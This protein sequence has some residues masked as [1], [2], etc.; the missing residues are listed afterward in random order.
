MSARMNDVHTNDARM[1]VEVP[2]DGAQSPISERPASWYAH[3]YTERF[4]MHLV[5][6][7]PRRKYPRSNNWGK[8]CLSEPG[9][10]VEFYTERP[11]WNMGVALGPSGMCSLDIDCEDSFR[12]ICECFGID[13]DALISQTPTVR[14]RGFRL[15]FRVP[16]GQTL[17]YHK[18][19]WPS[20]NDPTGTKHR[21]AVA[22]AQ[23]AKQ[24]GNT[25]RERRI[26]AVAK[27]WAA[28]TVFE[29]RAAGDGRQ[30]QDVLPPSIHPDTER[31]YAWHTQPRADWPEPPVWLMAMWTQFNAFKGQIR[32]MCPWAE[33]PKPPTRQKKATPLRYNE[34]GAR[35]GMSVIQ[36]FCA[37]HTLDE[38]LD[39][40]GYRQISERRYLSPHSSTG[41]PG[42]VMLPDANS[43]WIHHAS[44]PLCSESSGRP[45][46]AFDLYAAY[47]H[48]G[49][50]K[51]AVKQAAKDLGLDSRAPSVRPPAPVSSLS[52]A[53]NP[54][55]KAGAA[56]PAGA[57]DDAVAPTAAPVA[58]RP[59]VDF[60][61]PL[62]WANDQGKPLKHVDNLAE[63]CN[64]LGVTIRYNVI[65]KEEEI[66]IPYESFS[67]DNEANASLAWLTSECSLFGFPTDKLSEFVGYLADKNL[68]NPVANWIT[69][70]PWDGVCR[71]QDL[72][73]TVVAVGEHAREDIRRLKE[74]LIKRWMVSAVAAVMRP[75][76]VGAAGV[77]VFQGDQYIGKTKWFKTLVPDHLDVLKDGML[78]RPD[79]KDSV[80]QVCSY[81]LVE[82]GE[83]DATFRKSDI[84]ALKA[85]ITSDTDVLRRPYARRESRFAR[86]TVFFGSV[87]ER[88]FLHDPTGNRRYWTIECAHINHSHDI[89]MQQVWAEVL[90]MYERGESYYLSDA[91]MRMLNEHNDGFMAADPVEE[92][93]LGC[94]AWDDPQSLWQWR[95]VMDVMED[96]GIE[97]PS[98]GDLG[99]A[100]KVLRKLNGGQ[101]KRV[102]G[103][104]LL[105][106]PLKK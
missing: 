10:A 17:P 77:L 61:S 40:Y 27:R 12:L 74:V 54:A 91:E 84:A 106:A 28:F 46:N 1:D 26:R 24:A 66:L 59:P 11:N 98:K 35:R 4:G 56:Q 19:S 85:F 81:W 90:Y 93:I 45:V 64:R 72:F 104:N 75:G 57:L 63:I 6:I 102:K 37:A 79:D 15:L 67:I 95:Q 92:R 69:S 52:V 8:Q 94:L 99:A 96:C 60:M 2:S 97:R 36:Q 58:K 32:S 43:C 78:L 87:N 105:L 39:R 55:A 50:I 86:R 80:K 20:R 101:G 7:E 22:A 18:V 71:L 23:E 48:N 34:G 62:P 82:L 76:G 88:E 47:D 29:L 38:M 5:P 13:L 73:D 70:T 9:A 103:R 31:P 83:L 14:G 44:D 51:Q 21:A 41:L 25:E 100:A 42:V 89:D 3:R 30:R 65:S 33:Q 16:D 49:D 53:G 68:Y